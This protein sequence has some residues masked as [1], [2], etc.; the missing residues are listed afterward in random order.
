MRGGFHLIIY[1]KHK[2][3][4]QKKRSKMSVKYFF[5]IIFAGKFSRRTGH[6]S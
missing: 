2:L 6:R 1:V 4:L 5:I 3:I